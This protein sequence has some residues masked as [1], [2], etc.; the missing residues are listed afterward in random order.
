[1]FVWTVHCLKAIAHEI[2]AAMTMAS[3]MTLGQQCK[4]LGIV[5]GRPRHPGY[6]MEECR[7]QSF[8]HFPTSCPVRPADL[9]SAGF[10]YTGNGDTVRCFYCDVG[11][12]EWKPSDTPW[13]EHAHWYPECMFLVTNKGERFIRSVQEKYG[14]PPNSGGISTASFPYWT[15]VERVQSFTNFPVSCPLNPV[16]L[17]TA[18]FF[19]GGR[20][21]YVQCF[22]CYQSLGNWKSDSD[23]W[24]EHAR[25]YPEC[26]YLIAIKGDAFIR[27]V[28]KKYGLGVSLLGVHMNDPQSGLQ[29]A[30]GSGVV[31]IGTVEQQEEQDMEEKEQYQEVEEQQKHVLEHD[32]GASADLIAI[33]E[34]N[35]QLKDR[36]LCKV[37]LDNEVQTAFLPCGHAVCCTSCIV[38]LGKCPTCRHVVI[39]HVRIFMS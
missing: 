25:W 13:E 2:C 8:T 15:T 22:C 26:I 24:V 10:F 17:A 6:A 5:I 30:D 31:G 1:M 38:S 35:R 27:E 37:C 9:A 34:E 21:D 20:M 19:Y 29:A 14:N 28:L 12:R 7:L 11:M 36:H 23:P 33:K 39:G 18:G 4:G 32:V 16:D 3:A